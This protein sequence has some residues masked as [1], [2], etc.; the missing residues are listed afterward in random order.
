MKTDRR[1]PKHSSKKTTFNMIS[2]QPTPAARI[3]TFTHLTQLKS[4]WASTKKEL[5]QCTKICLC[6]QCP[7]QASSVTGKML[8][9][10]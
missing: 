4:K 6:Y 3:R 1:K 9:Y 8:P 7:I 2:F 5:S 10:T